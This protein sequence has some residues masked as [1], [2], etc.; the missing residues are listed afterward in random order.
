MK[1]ESLIPFGRTNDHSIDYLLGILEDARFTT[2][3]RVNEI[4]TAE[5]HW[6]FSE[7][8]NTVAALLSHIISCKHYM[9]IHFIEGKEWTKAQ[10]EEWLPGL[11]MGKYI[12]QLITNEPI[13]FYLQRL[14]ESYQLFVESVKMLDTEAF[15]K[16]REGYDPDTGCNLA[17]VL[18][19]VAEDEVHHRGQISLL[20]KLYNHKNQSHVSAKS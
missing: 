16:K 12:P 18:Y 13:E 9:R 19:H 11:E 15:H 7:G 10:N 6:Q 5:L 3:Q 20:R 14:E 8:W 17:W 2:L 1:R 4:S